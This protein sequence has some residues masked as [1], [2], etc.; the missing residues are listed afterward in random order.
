MIRTLLVAGAGV[1]LFAC[2]PGQG[3]SPMIDLS[4]LECFP[5]QTVDALAGKSLAEV[6]TAY[7]EPDSSTAFELAEAYLSEF[8]A[9]LMN[10]LQDVGREGSYPIQEVTWSM[11]DCRLTV[12]AHKPSGDWSVYEAYYYSKEVEF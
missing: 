3:I 5:S 12:W 10:L 6:L 7:G 11:D 4:S 8:Q 9:P 1:L 2:N